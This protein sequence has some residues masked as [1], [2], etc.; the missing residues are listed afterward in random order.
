MLG[1]TDMWLE[2]E[3]SFSLYQSNHFHRTTAGQI[4]FREALDFVYYFTAEGI[5]N[6]SVVRV[7][8]ILSKSGSSL[9]A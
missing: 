7:R 2:M 6:S 8:E 1:H 5:S 3:G 9:A 4:F